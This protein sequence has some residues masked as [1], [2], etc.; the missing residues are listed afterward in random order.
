MV[1]PHVLARSSGT[2]KLKLRASE[3]T[4]RREFGDPDCSD[5]I[6]EEL[7]MVSQNQNHASLAREFRQTV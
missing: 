4:N 6:G 1:S 5:R 2:S 7:H 3:K